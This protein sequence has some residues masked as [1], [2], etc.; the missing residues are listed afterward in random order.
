MLNKGNII[1]LSIKSF[2]F[3]SSRFPKFKCFIIWTIFCSTRN[4]SYSSSIE[5][6]AWK[7]L[8]ARALWFALS[9]HRDVW[10]WTEGDIWN[11]RTSYSQ[12]LSGQF[13]LFSIFALSILRGRRL[14]KADLPLRLAYRLFASSLSFCTYFSL[15]L[16]LHCCLLRD[17]VRKC[18]LWIQNNRQLYQTFQLK[19]LRFLEFSNI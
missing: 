6:F 14:L 10:P 4:T 7:R 19:M 5:Y 8:F 12:W 13:A 9:L 17:F 15:T 3:L 11:Q 2:H 18:H 1:F 16:F